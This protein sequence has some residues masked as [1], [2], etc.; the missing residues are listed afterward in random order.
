MKLALG[1]VQFGIPYG[2]ANTRGRPDESSVGL[3]L[4]R[5]AEAGVRVIDTACLYGE[6]EAVLGR[7]LPADHAFDVVTKTPKFSGMSG[8]DAA[9]ALRVAFYDSCRRL[10]TSH[11]YGLLAHDANDLLGPVGAALWQEMSALRA[12]GRVTKIGTSVYSGTQIDALLQRYTP[13]LMQLPLSVLDQRLVRG[14]QLDRLL[15]SGVEVHAR[16]VFLQGALL[17]ASDSL[18]QHLTGLRPSVEHIAAQ[19]SAYGIDVLTAG[20]RYVANLP[21]VAAVVCGVDGCDQFDELVAALQSTSQSLSPSEAAV[22]ACD[23]AMLLD[24]SQWRPA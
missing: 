1:T 2:V 14:G 24:P 3:I 16:S 8:T 15:A 22:C 23:D 11:V 6:S 17:M 13:D 18:P 7:C 20:L 12:A 4:Q 9:L 19:A 5:A 10:R 21:Q